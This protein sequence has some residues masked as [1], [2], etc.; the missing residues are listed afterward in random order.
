M[1]V[2]ES[3]SLKGKIAVITG[4]AGHLG[5]AMS[6]A[7]NEAGAMVAVIELT[8]EKF[9][10][11]FAGKD[12]YFFVEG[13]I[14]DTE[15]IKNCF[16]KIMEKYGTIDILINNAVYLKGGGC[17]PEQITDEMW[18]YSA[19]GVLGSVF[20]CIREVIPFMQKTGGSIINIASMYGVIV[21]ELSMYEGVCS[22]YLNP[23]NYGALKAGVIQMT[24]YFGAYLIPKGINVNS[25]TPGT[26]PSPKVQNNE[27]F[28]R[29]LS[30]KNP[31]NRIG[32]PDD[33]KGAVVFLA[34]DASKYIVGQNIIVDG[35][36]S[37]W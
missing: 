17:L 3:F 7:L 25:I 20:R 28:I 8:Q 35:G 21:P 23:V 12:N 10:E 29:R 33:L 36:W 18:A 31:A 32:N 30:K 6:E 9:A 37:L 26:F 11:K 27:E 2:I 34:S 13:N 14:S 1:N 24:K 5:T 19:D 22:P 16:Q 15:N 4:G